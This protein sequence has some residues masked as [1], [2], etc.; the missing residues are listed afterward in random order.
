MS[1]K[2]KQ[3]DVL[4]VGG[5]P[6]GMMA[7]GRAAELGSKVC[8]LEKNP[9]LGK[10]LRI[11]GGG[12]C[13]ITNAEF[14]VQKMVGK[15]G[16]KGK[17]LFS[18]F[19]RFGVQDT[20]DFFHGQGLETMVEEG[21]RVFPLSESAEDVTRTMIQY[22][23][24]NKVE[25]K[26]DAAVKGFAV[27]GGKIIGVK[28]ADQI[29]YAKKIILATGGKSHPETGSTGEG[30]GWLKK[31]DLNVVD[32]ESALV[33]VK[34]SE[35]W[36]ADL[37]GLSYKDARVTVW[38]NNKPQESRSGK[39]LFTHF[40]L[41]GPLILNMSKNI[42]EYLKYAPA[43]LSIDLRPELDHK[44]L[45]QEIQ[46]VFQENQN[47]KLK[48]VLPILLPP[49]LLLL[50]VKLNNL[51]LEKEINI[52]SRDERMSII[53]ILKDFK[54]TPIGLLGSDKAVVTSGGL[55]LKEVDVKTLQV[56]KYPNLY[57]IGDVLDFERPSG[58][59][60]LQVCWSTG[61]VSG[62]HAAE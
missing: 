46:K 56:K 3:Y 51:D 15:Y 2:T 37:M 28:I 55:D 34:V 6:A 60:S 54:L 9:L 10:K 30:F 8:L 29:I 5:G 22:V 43:V 18:I 16:K 23:K 24:K 1:E 20:L 19:S 7:A 41:S 39:I 47:K 40:G 61:F 35:P 50:A 52:V 13:N 36:I 33:P 14:D 58:G 45:D 53:K 48:N 44:Q 62:S 59:Y 27:E 11:T 49:K 4:V 26:A 21:N 12:R 57:V 17:A 38:Q 25:V 32:Q 42:G 31:L